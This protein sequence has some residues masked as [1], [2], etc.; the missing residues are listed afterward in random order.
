MLDTVVDTEC[1]AHASG[2]NAEKFNRSLA[3]EET[4]VKKSNVKFSD[5]AGLQQAKQALREAII[6]PLQ[7]PQLFTGNY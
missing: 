4:I 3:I 2:D 1:S 5:V 7:Y 6:M